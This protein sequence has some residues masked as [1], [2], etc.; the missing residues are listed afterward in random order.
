MAL[1]NLLHITLE[2]NLIIQTFK[3]SL[4]KTRKFPYF[5]DYTSCL[6]NSKPKP[7]L[8]DKIAHL[9]N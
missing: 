8:L 9:Y 4:N 7:M 2:P 1:C 6:H 5:H 3:F